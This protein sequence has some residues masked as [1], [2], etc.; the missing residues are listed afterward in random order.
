MYLPSTPPRTRARLTDATIEGG[1]DIS[2][3]AFDRPIIFERCIFR[4]ALVLTRAKLDAFSLKD[5][6]MLTV[7]ARGAEIHGDLIISGGSLEN[8]RKFA[9]NGHSMNVGNRSR[10]LRYGH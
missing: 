6:R 7:D 8:P 5:C 1:L 4:G 10:A 3:V 9:F 2:A